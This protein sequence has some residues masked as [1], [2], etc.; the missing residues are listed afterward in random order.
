MTDPHDLL[1]PDEQL[2]LAEAEHQIQ[3]ALLQA[4]IELAACHRHPDLSLTGHVL[5]HTEE[6]LVARHGPGVLAL[7]DLLAENPGD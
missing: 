2:D 3:G 1:S 4:E 5:A 6:E 7:L